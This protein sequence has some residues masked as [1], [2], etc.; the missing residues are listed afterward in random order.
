[1]AATSRFDLGSQRRAPGGTYQRINWL[2]KAQW[3]RLF[4]DPR[5][6]IEDHWYGP[7]LLDYLIFGGDLPRAGR[8]TGRATGR[9]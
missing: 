7:L 6:R 4:A 3:R 9:Q 8:A 1:M 2:T 5:L